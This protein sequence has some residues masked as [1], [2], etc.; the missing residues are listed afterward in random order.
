M[1]RIKLTG[2]TIPDQIA[3]MQRK[4]QELKQAQYTSQTSGFLGKLVGAAEFDSYG[5]IVEFSTSSNPTPSDISHIPCPSTPPDTYY[6]IIADQ[7]FYPRNGRPAVAV[8]FMRMSI[9]SGGL[10]GESDFVI[11]NEGAFLLKMNIYNASNVKVGEVVCY[12]QLGNYLRTSA[13]DDTDYAWQ[14]LLQYTCSQS[15]ELGYEFFVRSS[16]RGFT[17]SILEGLW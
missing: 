3:T 17:S 6:T 12:Q 1:Q 16:D 15:F 7:L 5:D 14:T 8:P 9:D 10:H 2:D 4:I 11:E 13:A